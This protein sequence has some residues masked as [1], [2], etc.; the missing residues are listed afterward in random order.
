MFDAMLIVGIF[1]VIALCVILYKLMEGFSNALLS[2]NVIIFVLLALAGI[3]IFVDAKNFSDGFP[4]KEKILLIEDNGALKQAFSWK[5]NQTKEIPIGNYKAAFE[6]ENFDQVR[7]EK[8]IIIIMESRI[9][10]GNDYARI[11]DNLRTVARAYKHGNIKTYPSPFFFT[12]AKILPDA[13][14]GSENDQ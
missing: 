14:L 7:Q 9:A 3:F 2:F 12:I 11:F 1:G 13:V 10:K 8:Q 6:Q 5:D 4:Q